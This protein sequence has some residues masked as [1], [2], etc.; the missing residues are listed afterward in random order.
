MEVT[1][2]YWPVLQVP[3]IVRSVESERVMS[4]RQQSQLLWHMYFSSIDRILFTTLEVNQ[5]FISIN[6]PT[7]AN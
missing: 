4:L 2:L 5:Y 1:E 3:D 7:S 6:W